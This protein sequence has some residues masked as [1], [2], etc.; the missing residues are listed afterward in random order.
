MVQTVDYF[1]LYCLLVSQWI[2]FFFSGWNYPLKLILARYAVKRWKSQLIPQQLCET[3]RL[4]PSECD[5]IAFRAT[6]PDGSALLLG[7]KKITVDTKS[8]AE[9]TVFLKLPDGRSFKLVRKYFILP[10]RLRDS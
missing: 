4:E 1:K 9:V 10:F 2:S 3:P 7:I 8:I 5:G 6:S